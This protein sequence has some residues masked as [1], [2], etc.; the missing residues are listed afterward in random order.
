MAGL[1]GG[2]S[3]MLI[4]VDLWRVTAAPCPSAWHGGCIGDSEG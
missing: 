3:R 4:R 2:S 1:G